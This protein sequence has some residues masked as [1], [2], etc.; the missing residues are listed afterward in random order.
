MDPYSRETNKDY[1]MRA[2]KFITQIKR[3]ASK[4]H[5]QQM[6]GDKPYMSHIFDV[7]RETHAIVIE[8]GIVDGSDEYWKYIAVAFGHDLIEDTSV[9]IDTLLWS[10]IPVDAVN[11]IDMMTKRNGESRTE[12]IERVKSDKYSHLVKQADSLSN[13][14][15]SIRAGNSKRI[16]KYTTYLS[17]LGE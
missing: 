9:K 11:G 13:L 17:I 16:A 12:Y 6:Y 10:N 15:H 2:P 4:H 5:K 8:R 3:L 1:I 14:T 7:V